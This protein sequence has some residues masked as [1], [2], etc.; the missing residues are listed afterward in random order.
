MF[1]NRGRNMDS[2]EHNGD[3]TA[4]GTVGFS[5]RFSTEKGESGFVSKK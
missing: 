1:E 5:G 4:V 2:P 3:Q